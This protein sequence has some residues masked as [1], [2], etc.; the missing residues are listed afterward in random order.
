MKK[1][2]INAYTHF[3]IGDD[4][5]IKIL[6]ERYPKSKFVLY[7]PSQ[8]KL[9]FKDLKNISFYPSDSIIVRGINY[10][11]RKIKICGDFRQIL[12]NSCD[13]TVQI[14]GSLFIQGDNWKERFE[15]A[16]TMINA[17]KPYFLLGANFGP[18]TDKEYFYKHKEIFKNF[19]DICFREKYSYN[20]FKD[21]SNVRMADDI[22]FQLHPKDN[23]ELENTIIISV[24]KPS[25]RKYL[26]NYNEI[27]YRKINEIAVYFL[28]REF[29]VT[30]VSFCEQEGDKEAVDIIFELIP[31]KFVSK[32]RRHYYTV[33]IEET[34]DLIA[35]SSFVVASRFHAMIIG[36]V[37]KKP[38]FPIVYSD[39]M[40]NVMKDVGF[41][42]T[43]T[44]FNDINDLK[45]EKVFEC[46]R[47]NMIDV[48]IQVKNAEK[49]FEKLDQFLLK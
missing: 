42:G 45:P 35:R 44:D 43:Y 41:K 12:A 39:K 46:I 13:A 33:N 47:T 9:C 2:M 22:I 26:S 3:N 29:N 24:I 15:Y 40:T 30:L 27:Y 38:V 11:F 7:A 32:V 19:S 34:I 18:Y 6:C 16:K 23:N 1:I 21:L 31:E 5:F 8:Y 37:F 48:S 17:K 25:T 4:L 28:K 36:W 10:I 49:H 14:G 20:M